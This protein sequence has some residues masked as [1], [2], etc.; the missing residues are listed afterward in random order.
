[1]VE[2]VDPLRHLLEV[3]RARDLTVRAWTINLHNFTLGER[4]PDTVAENA[5]GDRLLSDLCPAN[6]DARA[7]ARTVTSERARTGVEAIVA[8]SVCYMPFDHGFHHERTPYPLSETVRMFLS[9]CFCQDCRAW[10]R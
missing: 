3:G 5:F 1:M 9:L 4:F 7:Y 6:S 10:A 8:E 2:E